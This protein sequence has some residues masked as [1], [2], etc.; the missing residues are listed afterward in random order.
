MDV[1][2]LTAAAARPALSSDRGERIAFTLRALG[3]LLDRGLRLGQFGAELA[4]AVASATGTERAILIL[5]P[6]PGPLRIEFA[7]RQFV[8]PTSVRALL[9]QAIAAPPAAPPAPA[10]AG[11][12]AAAPL[13]APAV[14]A[15]L[16]AASGAVRAPRDASS[17]P[18]SD[19]PAVA[20]DEPLVDAAAPAA[21][22]QRIAQRVQTCGVFFESH[23]AQWARGDRSTDAVRAEAQQLQRAFGGGEGAT[24]AR[25]SVALDVLHRQ[26]IA[27]EGP[28]WAGQPVRLLIGREPDAAREGDA[29]RVFR[30]RLVLELPRLGRVEVDLRL[31]GDAIAADIAAAGRAQAHLHAALPEFAAALQ[32]RGLRPVA[33]A[34]QAAP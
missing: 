11:V 32:A 5:P 24:E 17:E 23:L 10:A 33:L 31:A 8:L 14:G 2:A 1:A 19:A 29:Q 25:A 16:L 4:R 7:G 34:A 22:A 26:S 6:G 3:P 21:T 12:P 27:L 28:A 9:L 20:F 30:A 18:R 15:A 13:L